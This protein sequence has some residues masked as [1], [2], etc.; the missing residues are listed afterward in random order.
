[1]DFWL[2]LKELISLKFWFVCVV[3]VLFCC[4]FLSKNPCSCSNSFLWWWGAGEPSVMGLGVMDPAIPG[5][6]DLVWGAGSL[7]TCQMGFEVAGR[8]VSALAG[9]QAA[10][11]W[12]KPWFTSENAVEITMYPEK[13]LN[14][15]KWVF[16][17]E[18]NALLE[19]FQPS[20]I[21]Y[22]FHLDFTANLNENFQYFYELFR[23]WMWDL[24]KQ[25]TSLRKLF[26]KPKIHASHDTAP[27]CTLA[28]SVSGCV[29]LPAL[30]ES[31][32]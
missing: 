11:Y 14:F 16:S 19:K 27:F 23:W 20:L 9:N 26:M 30:N 5:S 25:L 31:F 29:A 8:Q 12:K 4:V 24:W 13:K 1:M 21:S 15:D 7:E 17:K 32:K 3:F 6:A 18:K 28:C 22:F 2:H 10:S